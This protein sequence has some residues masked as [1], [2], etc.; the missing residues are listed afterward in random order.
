LSTSS[1]NGD[2]ETT[3]GERSFKPRY[4]VVRSIFNFVNCLNQASM[5]VAG[6]AS[7]TAAGLTVGCAMYW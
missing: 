3:K 6:F 5:L 7:A 1:D 2:A 4:F